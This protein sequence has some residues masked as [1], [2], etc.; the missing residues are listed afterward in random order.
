MGENDDGAPSA[1]PRPRGGRSGSAPSSQAIATTANPSALNE[2]AASFAAGCECRLFA[3][4]AT[5][6]A[7][8]GGGV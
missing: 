2:S 1:V 5:P 6:A 7:G 4:H 3:L 8:G